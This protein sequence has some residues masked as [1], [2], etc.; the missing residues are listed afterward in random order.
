MTE[1]GGDG[2]LAASPLMTPQ[3]SPPASS[4]ALKQTT[5]QIP[6]KPNTTRKKT[7]KSKDDISR[8]DSYGGGQAKPTMGVSTAE[9]STV[10]G[11]D[12]G[13]QGSK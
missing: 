10:L 4:L 6:P 13:G 2:T 7:K 8:Q 11:D 9:E 3:P 5:A 12:G 1:H